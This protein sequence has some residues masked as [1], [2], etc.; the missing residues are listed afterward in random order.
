MKRKRKV[1]IT[2][3]RRQTMTVI[4]TRVPVWC[5]FCK[6]EVETLSKADAETMI[7]MA[8]RMLD[9]AV[10]SGRIHLIEARSGFSR[11]CKAS[12]FSG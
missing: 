11:V 2:K 3:M 5:P 8:G 10:E 4:T 6:R 12:L 1:T 9:D 7:Q